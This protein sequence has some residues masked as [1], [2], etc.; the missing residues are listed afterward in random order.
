MVVSLWDHSYARLNDTSI[1]IYDAQNKIKQVIETHEQIVHIAGLHDR[2]LCVLHRA[3]LTLYHYPEHIAKNDFPL[4][5]QS[6]LISVQPLPD[7]GALITAWDC[8]LTF[9]RGEF[10]RYDHPAECVCP[11]TESKFIVQH[12]NSISYVR[13]NELVWRREVED[14]VMD[15]A[16]TPGKKILVAGEHTLCLY[17]IVG[18]L[19]QK[20]PIESVMEIHNLNEEEVL[21]VT[22][23]RFAMVFNH[24]HSKMHF[25]FS[26]ANSF[27]TLTNKV[28]EERDN[29]HVYDLDD[30]VPIAKDVFRDV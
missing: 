14:R 27:A 18:K 8:I 5:Y 21:L 16:L 15:I 1:E 28:I 30:M 10:R 23:K 22:R 7:G 19:T 25:Y 6:C 29:V 9:S 3:K 13:Q 4:P 12:E 2:S 24:K 20:W 11:L 17:S 26:C